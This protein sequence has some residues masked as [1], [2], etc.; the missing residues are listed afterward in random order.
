MKKFWVAFIVCSIC[1]FLI[2]WS[3]DVFV[4]TAPKYVFQILSDSFLVVGMLAT[5][6]ALLIFV[7]NE[8]TFDLIVY[9]VRSF[10]SFFKKDMTRKYDTFFDYRMTRQEKKLPFLFLLICGV[11]FLLMSVVMYAGYYQYL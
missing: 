1:T 2:A 8:G 9:G 5:C 6:F 10:W 11:I 4:Q 3:R 7:S